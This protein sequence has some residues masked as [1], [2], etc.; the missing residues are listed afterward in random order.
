M[1][2]SLT[3]VQTRNKDKYIAGFPNSANYVEFCYILAVK[4]FTAVNRVNMFQGERYN[5]QELT[6]ISHG[7]VLA[8]C[9]SILG[10][11]PN[12]VRLINGMLRMPVNRDYIRAK[13]RAA[14]NINSHQLEQLFDTTRVGGT[15]HDT[16]FNSE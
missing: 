14:H 3:A 10:A 4:K 13:N 5:N 8:T 16:V 1:N 12:T 2:A 7:K 9:V 6:N 11:Q 15:F